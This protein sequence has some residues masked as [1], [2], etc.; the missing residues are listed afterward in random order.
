[1]KFSILQAFLAW[2][3]TSAFRFNPCKKRAVR[4]NGRS[5][6]TSQSNPRTPLNLNAFSPE[7]NHAIG[8]LQDLPSAALA[9]SASTASSGGWWGAYLNIFKSGLLFVHDV[10]DAPLKSAGIQQTWGLA[11]ALFTAGMLLTSL[12][13]IVFVVPSSLHYPSV[14]SFHFSSFC[15][16]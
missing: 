13:E 12:F 16:C 7:L 2:Q 6:F 8:L 1:M 4:V 11:I 10:I 3:T 14:F 9:D 15:R 5:C